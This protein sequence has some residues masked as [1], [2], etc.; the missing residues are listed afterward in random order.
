M[1]TPSRS[2]ATPVP[3]RQAVSAPTRPTT[4]DPPPPPKPAASVPRNVAP[5]LHVNGGVISWSADNGGHHVSRG[6]LHAPRNAAGRETTYTVLGIVTSWKPAR[7]PVGPPCTTASRRE[8]NAGEQWTASEVSITGPKCVVQNV[9]PVLHVNGGVIS[10]SADKGANT[11]RGAISTAPR[12]AAGRTTTYTN[13]GL[14]TSWKPATPACGT[15][16]YYG[17]ASEGSAGEQWTAN[18]VAIAGP[19]CPPPPTE[20]VAPTLDLQIAPRR[21]S[22]AGVGMG[23]GSG[24]HELKL[25]ICTAARGAPGRSCTYIDN[26]GLPGPPFGAVHRT[27]YW[28]AARLRSGA[29]PAGRIGS[30][31][32]QRVQPVS[33][34]PLRST[35][36]AQLFTEGLPA[37]PP[38][39]VTG[40]PVGEQVFSTNPEDQCAGAINL[41]NQDDGILV[42]P[43]GIGVLT[44]LGPMFECET[45]RDLA[46]PSNDGVLGPVST[47]NQDHLCEDWATVINEATD[48]ISRWYVGSTGNCDVVTRYRVVHRGVQRIDGLR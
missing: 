26:I 35:S 43:G 47:V 31:L 21:G 15:T 46:A 48:F 42:Q 20:N 1:I 25:A 16:L 12:N 33:C 38:P 4:V 36:S 10:W 27:I 32:P 14:V 9:A 24:S 8:G 34:G 6:D 41:I 28:D 7:P 23:P 22:R 18:E 44:G 5:V 30:A 2:G 40:P 13:L 37:C 29:G 17:V 3:G 45:M 11:F 19:T 39:E